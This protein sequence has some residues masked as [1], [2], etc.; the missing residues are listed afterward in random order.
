MDE[1][2]SAR[3]LG[4]APGVLLQ[5]CVA[6]RVEFTDGADLNMIMTLATAHEMTPVRGWYMSRRPRRARVLVIETQGPLPNNPDQGL[7]ML[8]DY[9]RPTLRVLAMEDNYLR[10][11]ADGPPRRDELWW[12]FHWEHMRVGP[13]EP[14]GVEGLPEDWLRLKLVLHEDSHIVV[15]GR[16]DAIQRVREKAL[17]SGAVGDGLRL[18]VGE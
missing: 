9:G 6:V 16:P 12:Y 7:D 14:A 15:C 1:V 10:V 13:A 2:V 18:P 8:I 5:A 17:A 4:P 11:L 3:R